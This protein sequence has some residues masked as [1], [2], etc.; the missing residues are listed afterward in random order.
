MLCIEAR[1]KNKIKLLA[2]FWLGKEKRDCGR[3]LIER[4]TENMMSNGGELCLSK[5]AEEGPAALLC[6]CRITFVLMESEGTLWPRN[7]L[8][9]VKCVREMVCG[10][11]GVCVC[12]HVGPNVYKS[13]SA[14]TVPNGH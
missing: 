1:E 4:E 9:T 6:S 11:V 2:V 12:G 5:K 8:D 3:G 14:D 13:I 7:H 10:S